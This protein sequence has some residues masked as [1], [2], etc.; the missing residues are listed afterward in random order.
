[1]IS[2]ILKENEKNTYDQPVNY[3]IDKVSPFKEILRKEDY[4]SFNILLGEEEKQIS[5]GDVFQLQ[6]NVK[7]VGTFHFIFLK[8]T[9]PR[10]EAIEKI[11][12]LKELNSKDEESAKEKL[13]KLFEIVKE[14]N[15]LFYIYK[16]YESSLLN[17]DT[18]ISLSSIEVPLFI[19]YKEVSK[20]KPEKEPKQKAEKQT[21]NDK[22]F[23]IK[24]IASETWE[25][26][27][28]NRFH[29]LLLIVSTI[30][31]QTSFPLAIMNVIAMNTLYIF[32][33][34]CGAIGT[35][36]NAY[37]YYDLYKDEKLISK[38]TLLSLID[39]VLSIGVG[40][41]VFAIFYNISARPEGD[42]G[43]GIYTL[44]GIGISFGIII[45]SILISYLIRFILASKKAR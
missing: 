35:A 44:I 27:K 29:F 38:M 11:T 15:P 20:P 16:E 10:K 21:K 19:A 1:M 24:K 30:L 18:L 45:L 31:F 8:E 26:I 7:N 28:R 13:T 23:D 9:F 34:I 41:G 17:K 4:S 3:V 22:K 40:I 6:V 37:N 33:F 42:L 14:L 2:F 12:P 39:N 32:L 36:M 25:I 5:L 43:F